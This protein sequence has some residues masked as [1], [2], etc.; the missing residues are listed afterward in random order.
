MNF[1]IY[2]SHYFA[3][4]IRSLICCCALVHLVKLLNFCCDF[5]HLNT[6]DDP[7]IHAKM[8][9][10]KE[11]HFQGNKSCKV[12][13]CGGNKSCKVIRCG[14]NRSCSFVLV[15]PLVSWLCLIVYVLSFC[16]LLL[17]WFVL[18]KWVF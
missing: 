14:G 6:L 16:S 7:L 2:Q 9:E 15:S 13:R 1:D 11:S 3:I 10:C 4:L 5:R 8:D 12:I 17:N 18:A